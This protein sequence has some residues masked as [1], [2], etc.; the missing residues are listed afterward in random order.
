MLNWPACSPDLSPIENIGCIIRQKI[1]QRWPRNSSAAGNLYQARMRPN[2]N[3]KTPETHNLDAQTSSNC[4]EKKKICYTV[5]N[6]PSSQL[7]WDL[8]QASN[9][10]WAHF[11]YK[12][13]N[14]SQFKHLL[15]YLCSIVNGSCDL[16]LFSFSF[17]S[18]LK[19]VPIFPKFGLYLKDKRVKKGGELN[20][21]FPYTELQ[22]RVA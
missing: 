10:K 1:L 6:M 21:R 14:I 17:Y 18:K 20:F 13:V 3:T 16:K 4:F 22:Y 11:V 2:S 19:N 8:W 15:Y 9:L 5:V 12:I 7:F